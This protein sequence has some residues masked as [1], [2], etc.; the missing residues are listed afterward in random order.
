[1]P[2]PMLIWTALPY[3][4]DSTV[5]RAWA[6]AASTNAFYIFGG[7]AGNN[8]SET[9]YKYNVNTETWTIETPMP[10]AR[11][12][13]NL[14]CD[15]I[16]GKI[17]VIGGF[18]AAN[19]ESNQT[20]EYDPVANSWNTSRANAPT[21]M[22]GSGTSIIGRFIYLVGSWNGGPGS[23]KHERYDIVNDVWINQAFFRP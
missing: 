7:R 5:C 14:A 13:A 2:R 22:A 4:P 15:N 1:M 6:Y 9:T 3:G 19:N 11:Y 17:F 12:F 18:D 21:P 23:T 10:A 16:T 8:V 20:W